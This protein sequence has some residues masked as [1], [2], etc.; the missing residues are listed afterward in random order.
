MY[1]AIIHC[2]WNTYEVE[3]VGFAVTALSSKYFSECQTVAGIEE[4][5]LS[6][7]QTAICRD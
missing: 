5:V 2:T 4:A 7:L 3:D 1:W 6:V